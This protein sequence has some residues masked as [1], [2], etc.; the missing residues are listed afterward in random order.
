M[1]VLVSPAAELDRRGGRLAS[2]LAGR[3]GATVSLA[4]AGVRSLWRRQSQAEVH[5]IRRVLLGL[6]AGEPAGPRPAAEQTVG[7]VC[8]GRC[9]VPGAGPSVFVVTDHLNLTWWSPLRGQND[10]AWGPRF[11]VMTGLYRPEMVEERL[12]GGAQVAGVVAQVTEADGISG[13]EAWAMRALGL[14]VATVELAPVAILAAHLGYGLA[15]V[16]VVE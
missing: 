3:E 4:D 2:V 16:V 8:R 13:H 14:T 10:A 15:A 1:R 11:P 12:S 5:A 9:V 6:G 7:Y